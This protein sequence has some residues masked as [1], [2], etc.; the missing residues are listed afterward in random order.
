MRADLEIFEASD[1]D[2]YL[3]GHDEDYVL[4]QPGPPERALFRALSRDPLSQAEMVHLLAGQGENL[5]ACEAIE[6]L[7]ASGLLS[8][9]RQSDEVPLRPEVAQRYDRQLAY[10]ALTHPGA[11]HAQQQ[12][13]AKATVVIVGVGGVGSWVAAALTCLGLGKLV[14]VDDDRVELSNLNRQVLFRPSDIGALKAVVAARALRAFNPAIEIE[15]RAERIRR[16][17][18]LARLLAGVSLVVA[19]ADWPPYRIARWI[20][21]ACV[22]AGVPHISAGQ[23]PPYIRVG[24]L[25]IPGATACF[26]CD[27]RAARARSVFYDAI[28]GEREHSTA[29]APTLGP[30]SALVGSMIGMEVLHYLTEICVPSTRGCAVTVDMRSWQIAR[31]EITRDE[32]CP[33]CGGL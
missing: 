6:K 32:E 7:L 9:Y 29:L 1:G 28:A 21:H 14:L 19:A 18:D 17:A 24:P 27:E 30:A 12:R 4:E 20:N 8:L 33:A 3:L 26:E 2:V 10:F 31:R 22:G 23:I 11:E 25:V 15:S 13:L 16:P 5:Q